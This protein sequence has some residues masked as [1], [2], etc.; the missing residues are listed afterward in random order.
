MNIT[1][2]NTVLDRRSHGKS[3]SVLLKTRQNKETAPILCLPSGKLIVNTNVSDGKLPGTLDVSINDGDFKKIWVY[4]LQN[5]LLPLLNI[6][7]T[8]DISHITAAGID[9]RTIV[10]P[11]NMDT[12]TVRFV[13]SHLS[14]FIA[15]IIVEAPESFEPEKLKVLREFYTDVTGTLPTLAED[16]PTLDVTGLGSNATI[17]GENK[18]W[19]LH[20]ILSIMHS[21]HSDPSSAPT[22]EIV[23][24]PSKLTFRSS[25][26][27][28]DIYND[29]FVTNDYNEISVSSCS[30][31]APRVE[32]TC[33]P[34][35]KTFTPAVML[36]MNDGLAGYWMKIRLDLKLRRWNSTQIYNETHYLYR[37]VT[38]EFREQDYYQYSDD[39][40]LGV[41][42]LSENATPTQIARAMF[43]IAGTT[44]AQFEYSPTPLNDIGGFGFSGNT[45]NLLASYDESSNQIVLAGMFDQHATTNPPE[46]PVYDS[47]IYGKRYVNAT[48][49]EAKITLEPMNLGAGIPYYAKCYV[50][51]QFGGPIVIQSCT[52]LEEIGV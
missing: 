14:Y 18:E 4:D 20:D 3:T 17:K 52:I 36:E 45:C 40:S 49:C 19:P 1:Y 13:N 21:L 10:T 25:G 28:D 16:L 24:K 44:D 29:V 12:S 41:V 50:T 37:V 47:T 48:G 43:N 15:Q 33:I 5:E 22:F 35:V 42:E 46:Y 31:L 11:S 26:D 8:E 32:Y 39:S 6:G 2:N 51:E 38:T 9:A 34:T 7:D 27:E 30:S 23:N